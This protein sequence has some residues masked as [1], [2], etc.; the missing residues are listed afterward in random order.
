MLL[1]LYFNESIRNNYIGSG[2]ISGSHGGSYEDDC[3]LGLDDGGSKH[4]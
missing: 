1:L 2:E 3:L 4:L